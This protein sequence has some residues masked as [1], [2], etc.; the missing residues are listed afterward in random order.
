MS[1]KEKQRWKVNKGRYNTSYNR[2]HSKTIGIRLYESD[3]KYYEYWLA[4]PNKSQWLKEKL[5]EYAKENSL[6]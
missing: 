3:M 2:E 6:D 4:I 1:E 5:D